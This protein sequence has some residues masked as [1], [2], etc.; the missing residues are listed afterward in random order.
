VERNGH[1][2]LT[3]QQKKGAPT[4]Y[5]LTEGKTG[6]L[7][8]RISLNHYQ[9]AEVYRGNYRNPVGQFKATFKRAEVSAY[10]TTKGTLHSNI[11]PCEK[12]FPEIIGTGQIRGTED[13]LIFEDR[14]DWKTIEIHIFPGCKFKEAEVLADLKNKKPQL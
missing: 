10:R 7:P 13:L 14:G 12:S 3:Y 1:L 4:S 2:K 8:N 6:I 11:Y 5:Y 9:P